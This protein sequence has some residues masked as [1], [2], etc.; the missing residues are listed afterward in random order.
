MRA[1]ARAAAPSEESILFSLLSSI[2][3]LVQDLGA[4]ARAVAS[5]ESI[6]F[7]LIYSVCKLVQDLRASAK[8]AICY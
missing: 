4:P 7:P 1:S 5:S 2:C 6:S 3:K 8:Y